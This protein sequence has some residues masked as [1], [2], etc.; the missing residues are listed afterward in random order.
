MNQKLTVVALLS[1]AVLANACGAGVDQNSSNNSGEMPEGI[2]TRPIETGTNSTPG[3]PANTSVNNV[4]RGATPTPGIPGNSNEA[5][6]IRKGT[7]PT[8]GIPD[9]ETI[10]RQLKRTDIDA[11]VVNQ[12]PA[13]NSKVRKDPFGRPR[14]TGSN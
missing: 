9:E 11:N 8:P 3:I 10:R 13:S 2:S 12:A 6:G 14:K 4:P 1:V 5:T 7:T